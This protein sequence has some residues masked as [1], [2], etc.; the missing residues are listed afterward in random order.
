MIIAVLKKTSDAKS[1]NKKT[2]NRIKWISLHT[3]NSTTKKIT[4]KG[5]SVEILEHF[6]S[7]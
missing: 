4:E 1:R 5:K 7:K 6:Y 3:D 2:T